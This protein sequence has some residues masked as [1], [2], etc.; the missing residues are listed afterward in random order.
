MFWCDEDQEQGNLHTNFKL[1]A[2][3]EFLALVNIDGVTI[4]DS[5]TFGDQSTDISY[6]R[7]LDGS[8]E[9]NFLS[10]TPGSTN[11]SLGMEVSEL[12]LPERFT[13]Y[14]NYPNPFNPITIIRYDLPKDTFVKVTIYDILGNVIKNLVNRS[15]HSGN[16]SIQWNA[17]NNIGQPVSAGLYLYTIE[18]AQFGQTKKMVL[19]K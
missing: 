5:I 16:N 10:P 1:N 9:W 2:G 18:A 7:V 19:L 11:S 14:Q 8:S 4:L 13:L 3:G 17:T 15:Q 12:A 6:G